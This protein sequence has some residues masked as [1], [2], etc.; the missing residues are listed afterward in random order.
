MELLCLCPNTQNRPWPTALDLV[1]YLFNFCRDLVRH[2]RDFRWLI[3]RQA[4]PR[5][6]IF[7]A[8]S[9]LYP[10]LQMADIALF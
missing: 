3:S 6:Q 7:V 1:S 10:R 8:I 2:T 4:Y 9:S 5:L